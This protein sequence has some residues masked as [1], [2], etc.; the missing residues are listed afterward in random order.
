MIMS[1]MEHYP[2]WIDDI[3]DMPKEFISEKILI[4]AQ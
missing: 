1:G 3:I 4:M 2:E